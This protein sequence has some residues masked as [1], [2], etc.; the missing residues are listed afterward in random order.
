MWRESLHCTL[1][2][3]ILQTKHEITSI[4]LN[5]Q[6][7]WL[8]LANSNNLPLLLPTPSFLLALLSLSLHLSKLIF[9]SHSHPLFSFQLSLLSSVLSALLYFA[10]A[11]FQTSIS[12]FSF[13]LSLLVADLFLYFSL[14]FALFHSTSVARRN[15][16]GWPRIRPYWL[17][18]PDRKTDNEWQRGTANANC[19]PYIICER[20][21]IA[22]YLLKLRLLSPPVPINLLYT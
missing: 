15:P 17:E 9:H 16:P 8:Y 20:K 12:Y 3:M 7:H 6:L 18:L 1:V 10:I 2:W 4:H 13:F 5:D 14:F 19:E 11:A 22:S 21:P